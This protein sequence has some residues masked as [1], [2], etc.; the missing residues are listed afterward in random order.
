[1]T[2]L[3]SFNFIRKEMNMPLED[4]I[5]VLQNDYLSMTEN[6]KSSFKIACTETTSILNKYNNS[7]NDINPKE[8]QKLFEL[9]SKVA[10]RYPWGLS[11]IEVWKKRSNG[12]VVSE[13]LKTETL[14]AAKIIRKI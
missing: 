8:A 10:S 7:I 3:N 13:E 14:H 5:S 2:E 1:M 12:E 4:L 9:W 11:K 6:E